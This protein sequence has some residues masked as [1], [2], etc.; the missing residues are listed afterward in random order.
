LG[1]SRTLDLA[2]LPEGS[3]PVVGAFHHTSVDRLRNIR[4]VID[5]DKGRAL[6]DV[7]GDRWEGI[8]RH[9]PTSKVKE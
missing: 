1:F 5:L 7:T 9:A 3:C 6:L 4:L 2:G 8:K